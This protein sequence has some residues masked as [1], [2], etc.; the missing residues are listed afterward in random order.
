MEIDLKSSFLVSRINS[1]VIEKVRG[2]NCLSDFMG[3]S[4]VRNE[5]GEHWVEDVVVKVG[6]DFQEG[7]VG[8]EV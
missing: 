2:K 1:E 3:G 5:L 6:L 4:S 7:L 8:F